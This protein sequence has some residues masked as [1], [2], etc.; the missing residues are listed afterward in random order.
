MYNNKHL[1]FATPYNI[2]ESAVLLI[3]Y[4]CVTTA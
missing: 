2:A 4:G 1:L 3:E